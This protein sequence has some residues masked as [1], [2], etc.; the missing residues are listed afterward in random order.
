[1]LPWKKAPG[2]SNEKFSKYYEHFFYVDRP[3]EAV[4]NCSPS[5]NKRRVFNN[6]R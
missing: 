3:L 4:Y 5:S 2:K 6:G 1:M